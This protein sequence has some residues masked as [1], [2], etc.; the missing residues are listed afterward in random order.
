MQ[1]K[2]AAVCLIYRRSCPTPVKEASRQPRCVLGK[3][4]GH[5][6]AAPGTRRNGYRVLSNQ[7]LR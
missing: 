4:Q 5:R 7:A 6:R 3:S 2:V 1:F